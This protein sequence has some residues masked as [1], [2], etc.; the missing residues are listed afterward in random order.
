MNRLF[1]KI[2]EEQRML[3]RLQDFRESVIRLT[4]PQEIVL[5]KKWGDLDE[6]TTSCIGLHALVRDYCALSIPKIQ[7]PSFL[8][9]QYANSGWTYWHA[10]N[11]IQTCHELMSLIDIFEDE[12]DPI[13]KT[14]NRIVNNAL[15]RANLIVESYSEEYSTISNSW[16]MSLIMNDILEFMKLIDRTADMSDIRIR[17]IW[18]ALMD[19][20]Q[21][22]GITFH[23]GRTVFS[24]HARITRMADHF[25]SIFAWDQLAIDFSATDIKPTIESRWIPND[26]ELSIIK[27]GEFV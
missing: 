8:T 21:R 20:V 7:Q 22:I 12:E 18:I 17:M 2:I 9:D 6:V 13:P 11:G 25:P 27:E 4:D 19:W 26:V 3:E 16:E 1:E 10:A 15:E 5:V 23:G 14:L 24:Q